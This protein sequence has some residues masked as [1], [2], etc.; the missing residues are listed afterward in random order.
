MPVESAADRAS[1]TNP[2]EFGIIAS[3]TVAGGSAQPLNGI[4]DADYQL[5]GAFDGS[6]GTEGA[7]PV[8]HVSLDDLPAG[9]ANGDLITVKSINYSVVEFME[10][11]TGMPL[12]RLQKS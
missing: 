1:F 12:L 9:S 3:Y 6:P 7:T 10:D 4:F 11:D 8:F 2:A 5:L